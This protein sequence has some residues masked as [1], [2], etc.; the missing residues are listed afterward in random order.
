MPVGPSPPVGL[1]AVPAAAPSPS[2]VRLRGPVGLAP[3]A[4]RRPLGPPGRFPGCDR[5]KDLRG[6]VCWGGRGWAV[7][8]GRSVSTSGA[9]GAGPL[10]R[11]PPSALGPPPATLSWIGGCGRGRAGAS[12]VAFLPPAMTPTKPAVKGQDK[13]PTMGPWA[14]LDRVPGG[15]QRKRSRVVTTTIFLTSGK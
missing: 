4:Y 9:G 15:C 13:R 2:S 14:A 12:C 10:A 8:F 5:V 6:L 3:L 1:A 7:R 11:I